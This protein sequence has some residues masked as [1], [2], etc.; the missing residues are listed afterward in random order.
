M[1]YAAAVSVFLAVTILFLVTMKLMWD[2]GIK[3]EA[4]ER[5]RL[6]RMIYGVEMNP[7]RRT[8]VN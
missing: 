7:P 8:K 4:L 6:Y 5:R 1:Y 3:Q 2:N